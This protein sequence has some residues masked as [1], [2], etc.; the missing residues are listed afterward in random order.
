MDLSGLGQVGNPPHSTNLLSQI[1]PQLI[2]EVSCGVTRGT[3]LYP[4]PRT[5]CLQVSGPSWLTLWTLLFLYRAH[6]LQVLLDHCVRYFILPKHE[7][8]YPPSAHRPCFPCSGGW[9]TWCFYTSD[10]QC[11]KQQHRLDGWLE[12]IRIICVQKIN[13]FLE[14]SRQ[15]LNLNN[16]Y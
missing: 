7:C 5:S 14:Q 2:K 8:R 4:T 13:S 11:N 12:L 3:F 1:N 15:L 10:Q 6:V 9:A 16:D